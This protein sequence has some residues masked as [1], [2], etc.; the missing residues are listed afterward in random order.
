MLHTVPAGP[1]SAGA[2]AAPTNSQ[3]KDEAEILVW[4]G[5]AFGRTKSQAPQAPAFQLTSAI[6]WGRRLAVRV[7]WHWN[8][9]WHRLGHR[10]GHHVTGAYG[11]LRT[12]IAGL[13]LAAA[14]AIS[15][16]SVAN[17]FEPSANLN[18]ADTASLAP[19]GPPLDQTPRE[20]APLEQ[21]VA[22]AS[23]PVEPAIETVHA[24]PEVK[25]AVE[26]PSTASDP[27]LILN[28]ERDARLA[29]EAKAAQLVTQA[30][31][32]RQARE[33]AENAR[34][35]ISVEL[36]TARLARTEAEEAARLARAELA[37][38]IKLANTA[39]AAVP[40]VSGAAQNALSPAIIAPA[41]LKPVEAV[42]QRRS[43]Q[44]VATTVSTSETVNTDL[45][46]GRKLFA[47]GHVEAARNRFERAA[48]SGL[49]EAALAAGN[50]FDPV[51][52][53]KAGL[54]FSGDPDRARAW[55]RR[56]FELAHNRQP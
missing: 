25:L 14:A 19:A 16:Y 22:A 36:E 39:N 37:E 20:Q 48:A 8:W 28:A 27:A 10:L 54:K 40:A 3:R 23:I 52:L 11:P 31:A 45:A 50:T 24:P 13:A 43:S 47:Q 44:P 56:A 5:S 2:D 34:A 51:S 29:A 4:M 7:R 42:P 6:R 33:S 9:L 30:A 41:I 15:A 53:T 21:T 49:A 12:M 18:G 1:V 32:E 26:S 55:Y 46:E 35:A 38:K 17:Q